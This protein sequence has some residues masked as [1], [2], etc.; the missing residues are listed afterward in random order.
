MIWVLKNHSLDAAGDLAGWEDTG[1]STCTLEMNCFRPPVL[2]CC[3][4]FCRNITILFPSAWRGK[5][6]SWVSFQGEDPVSHWILEDGWVWTSPKLM[7]SSHFALV[8]CL[9]ANLTHDFSYRWLLPCCHCMVI[10]Y[11]TQWLY[12]YA[13]NNNQISITKHYW[14]WSLL[15]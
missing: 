4:L 12:I 1:Y 11:W 5:C 2:R 14:D 3:C 10:S 8:P 6:E 15:P 9:M 13:E 7:D